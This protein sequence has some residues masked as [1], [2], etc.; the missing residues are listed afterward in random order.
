MPSVFAVQGTVLGSDGS[1]ISGVTVRT[2][3]RTTG[4][5][6]GTT[7]SSTGASLPVGGFYQELG[8]V[9]PGEVQVVFCAPEDHVLRND[10]IH[11]AFPF[12]VVV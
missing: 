11:R 1:P 8:V 4:E 9:D 2:Y 7:L 10:G 12:E 3:S 6:L 5:R